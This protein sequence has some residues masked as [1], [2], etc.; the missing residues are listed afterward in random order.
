MRF[1]SW[2]ESVIYDEQ[3]HRS[4]SHYTNKPKKD[5][6]FDYFDPRLP[7][8]NAIENW[9][10][11]VPPINGRDKLAHT[12][13]IADESRANNASKAGDQEGSHDHITHHTCQGP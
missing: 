7:C 1:I 10:D 6:T 11:Q 2:D 13:V 12:Q 9:P 4:E 3:S 8:R 5:G